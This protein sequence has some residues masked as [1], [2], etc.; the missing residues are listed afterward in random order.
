MGE[1]LNNLE[2]IYQTIVRTDKINSFMIVNNKNT[3]VNE[4]LENSSKDIYRD[5]L[6]EIFDKARELVGEVVLQLLKYWLDKLTNRLKLN[7]FQ[8]QSYL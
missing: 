3:I 2:H 4:N 1:I 8:Y 7:Q 5:K 6:R